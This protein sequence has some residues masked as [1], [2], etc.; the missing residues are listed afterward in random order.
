MDTKIIERKASQIHQLD[1]LIKHSSL[2]LNF[3][4]ISQVT[5]GAVGV[6]GITLPPEPSQHIK[7]T[8]YEVMKLQYENLKQELKEELDKK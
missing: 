3:S 5:I 8:I 2:V 4:G 1:K 7:D 6:N